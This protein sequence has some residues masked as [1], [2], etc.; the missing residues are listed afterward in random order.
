M[1]ETAAIPKLSITRSV[2]PEILDGLSQDSSAAQASRRD[3]RLINRLLGSQTWFEGTLQNSRRGGESVLE[4]GAG[5]G[6]LGHALSAI[7]PDMAGLD[8]GRRPVDW[9]QQAS[10][11]ETDVFDFTGWTDYPV[12]IGN[13]FF[14]H[15]DAAGLAHLG[16]RINEH[17]RVI[18]A[19]DPLRVRRTTTLF[20]LLCPLIHAHPVTRHDGR[21]SIAAGFRHDEL[22]SLLQLDPALW[23]WRVQE[24]WLGSS[25]LVAEKHA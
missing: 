22:P 21:V 4:I 3:L 1:R 12:V 18:I 17:A 24:T 15:F 16:A 8:L 7:V 9:P 23:H 25:R 2:Q 20:S 5:T 11:F 13:L 10:W 6:E 14:H 19:S